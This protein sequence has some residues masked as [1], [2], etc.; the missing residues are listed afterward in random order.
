MKITAKGKSLMADMSLLLVAII[1]GSGFIVN[2][3]MLDFLSPIYILVLRFSSASIIL[4]IIFHR[5][6]LKIKRVDL[7]AGAIMGVF[8]FLGFF[9][10]IVGMKYTVVSKSAFITASN[11]VMVPFLYWFISKKR[12]ESSEIIAASLCFIGIGILSLDSKFNLSFGDGLTFLCAIF[13]GMHI[14]SVGIFSRKHDPMILTIIQFAIAGLLSILA[15]LIFKVDLIPLTKK[16]SM[17]IGYLVIIN[18]I[19]AFSIQNIA[20]KYTTSTHAA[21]ILS[22]ESVFGTLFSIILLYEKPSLRLLFGSAIIFIAIILA[23]TNF[24]FL[25]RSAKEIEEN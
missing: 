10:Q 16:M 24:S 17:S 22:L 11:V 6:V 9:A 23:E 7:Q 13:F 25:K 18:T 20:Q 14:I 19:L 3:D 8:L 1:W 12:V 5:R 4:G 21:I 15:G 2:K